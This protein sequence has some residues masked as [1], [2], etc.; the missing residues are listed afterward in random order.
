MEDVNSKFAKLVV[1]YCVELKKFDEVLVRVGIGAY[2][3]TKYLWKAIVERSAYP[4]LEVRDDELNE[5]FFRYSPK[6]LLEYYSKINEYIM[7]NIDAII[8]VLGP[9]HSKPLVGI[10]PQRISLYSRTN[11]KITE[12]FLRR[13]SEG[14]LRWVVTAYPVPSL[15]QEACMSL[16]DYREFVFKALKLYTDD[17]IKA[18]IK[19]AEFQERIANMLNKVDE[20]R[21]VGKDTDLLLKVSGRIWINDDGKNN[22]PGGEVFSAPHED[23]VEGVI[24]FTYPAI[25]SGVEVEGIRLKFR[26]GE[27]IEAKAVKGEEFLNKILATDEGSKRVGEVAFGLNYD[28]QRF[29]KSILFDEKIGGTIHIALGSAYPKTGGKNKSSIHWDMIRDMRDGKVLA[30]GDVIYENGKF[31][32]EVI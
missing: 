19:Q 11:R 28:I 29:T 6:E 32:R 15:A 9:K 3:F 20:L 31:I 16:I 4:R 1:D 21:F 17:P 2:E 18:W 14:K 13:E 25:W 26:R 30:D 7:E 24:T 10:D 12:I 8:T 22:M 23:S 27:V 5:I